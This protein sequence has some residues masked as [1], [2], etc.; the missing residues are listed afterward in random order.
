MSGGA[1]PGG[2]GSRGSDPGA[3]ASGEG[4][5]PIDPMRF[6]GPWV[7]AGKLTVGGLQRGL[8]QAFSAGGIDTAMLDARILVGHALV[9]DLTGLVRDAERTVGDG[10]VAAAVGFA[11]RRLAGEPVARIL[12]E[13]EFRGMTLR[14]SDATLVPR[15]ETE[16][17]VEVVI[18]E[19]RA[20]GQAQA[21]IVIADLGVG[22]G[23]ILLALLEVLPNAVGVGIDISAEAVATAHSNAERFGLADRARFVRADF[24]AALADATFDVV[25]SNPPYIESG[26]IDGLAVE[27][28]RHD[29]RLALDG[30]V[31]GL[32]CYRRIIA[33]SLDALVAG[34]LCAVEIGWHQG[35]AVSRLFD[36][37]G[38]REVAVRRDLG[39]RD[40]VVTG[41]KTAPRD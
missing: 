3:S 29:P 18:A 39:G 14:L 8:A 38:Y 21:R 15:P 13:Q 37:A 27:V 34:G 10:D 23:A 12:G 2:A 26:E 16:T 11:R 28:R 4:S 1:H 31:D 22:S 35:A 36:V 6:L 19:I 24:A 5:V 17:L 7:R 40:R 9:L 20:V 25:V 41:R 33:E 32:D 30:G